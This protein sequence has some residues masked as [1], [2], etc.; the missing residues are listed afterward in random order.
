MAT[1]H[2]AIELKRAGATL[3]RRE[4]NEMT[5]QAVGQGL[6]EA[7]VRAMGQANNDRVREQVEE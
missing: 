7:G 2:R 3:Q 4:A 1:L 6:S 5:R